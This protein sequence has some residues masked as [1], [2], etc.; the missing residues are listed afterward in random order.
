MAFIRVDHVI[1]AVL[2]CELAARD[3]GALGFRSLVGGMHQDGYTRN[4]LIPLADGAYIELVSPTDLKEICVKHEDH[5]EDWLY[6]FNAGEGFAGFAL[7]VP[8]IE[9]AVQRIKNAGYRLNGPQVGVR[10]LP[11]GRQTRCSGVSIEGHRYPAIVS[12]ITP[13]EWR[14]PATQENTAHANGATGIKH[15]FTSTFK[16]AEAARRYEALSGLSALQGTPFACA[17]TVDFLVGASRIT[18]AE[19]TTRDSALY[20]DLCLRGEVPFLVLVQTADGPKAGLLDLMT[21]HRARL[22]LT[23]PVR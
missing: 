21:A 22:E 4:C 6:C 18:I 14:I 23:W 2:D 12:D 15:I 8:D 10:V 1:V 19:P 16:L 9:S 3:Y 5:G 11:D 7:N 20:E 17:R 13:R